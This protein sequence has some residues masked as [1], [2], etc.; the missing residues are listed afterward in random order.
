MRE[1]C[2]ARAKHVHARKHPRT[3]TER[4]LFFVDVVKATRCLGRAWLERRREGGK[5]RM[6]VACHGSRVMSACD[7]CRM[8]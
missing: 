4:D 6:Q 3:Q 1:T 8:M 2:G 5:A 7:T